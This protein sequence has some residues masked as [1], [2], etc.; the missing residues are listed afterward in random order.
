MDWSIQQ[1]AR[2]AGTTSRTLR[3]YG[4]IGLLPATRVGVNGYRYYDQAALAR[5]QRI[6][7]LR[8]LGLGLSDIAG[9]LAGV[10]DSSALATHLDWLR[11]EQQRLE[12]QIRSVEITIE[13]LKEGTQ[14][15]AEEML[16]GFDHTQYTTEV[17]ERWGADVAASSDRWWTGLSSND[18]A[19]F[20]AE[21]RDIQNAYARHF[22]TGTPTD[23]DA[24][25]ATTERHYAWV[26]AGWQGTRPNAEQFVGLGEMYVADERFAANYGGT[27]GAVYVR[28]AMA[29]W[30]AA[31]L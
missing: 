5:L 6:L 2:L 28:D 10:D 11:N 23:D 27:D 4:E 9:V 26:T 25:Q 20:T 14:L 29:A 13:K 3:H 21:Q 17:A 18:R 12:R 19:R 22:A 30:A 15:M 31:N 24:V 8:E 7:M 16:D 1:I